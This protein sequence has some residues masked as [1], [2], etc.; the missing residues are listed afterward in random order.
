[1]A[2]NDKPTTKQ[3][4]TAKAAA[5]GGRTQSD[6]VER[7]DSEVERD[8]RAGTADPE[9]GPGWHEETMGTNPQERETSG[10]F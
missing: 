9:G 3:Q 8:R 6:G 7:H 1:M 4:R 2:E 5:T 10:D